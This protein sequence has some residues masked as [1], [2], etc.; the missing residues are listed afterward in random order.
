MRLA[1]LILVAAMGVAAQETAPPPLWQ[2][3][4][5]AAEVRVQTDLAA[6][7]ACLDCDCA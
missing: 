4:Q 3:L 6:P 7:R 1:L 2:V 5:M